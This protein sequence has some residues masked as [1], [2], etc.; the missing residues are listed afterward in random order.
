MVGTG[1]AGG[2]SLLLCILHSQCFT[3]ALEAEQSDRPLP[4]PRVDILR[5]QGLSWSSLPAHA[6][7]LPSC[8]SYCRRLQTH[9]VKLQGVILGDVPPTVTG[10]AHT[11]AQESG[12][13]AALYARRAGRCHPQPYTQQLPGSRV[14][15]AS[16]CSKVEG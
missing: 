15:G 7:K 10:R 8:C 12:R 4:S 13:C 16:G 9:G 5:G 3:V 6:S 14:Q 2:A 1:G 11:I